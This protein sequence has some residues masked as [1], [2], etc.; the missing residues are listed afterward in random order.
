M[1]ARVCGVLQEGMTRGGLSREG[2]EEGKE[3]LGSWDGPAYTCF[4]HK[5]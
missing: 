4:L 5:V 3:W 2:C 1:Q